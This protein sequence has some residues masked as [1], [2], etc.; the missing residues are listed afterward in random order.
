MLVPV[1]ATSFFEGIKITQE[2][3][4]DA[5]KSNAFRTGCA[6]NGGL[7][8]P[9]LQGSEAITVLSE[10][11]KSYGLEGKMSISIDVGAEAFA[12]RNKDQPVRYDVGWK[13]QKQVVSTAQ[14][15]ELYMKL[16]D[17]CP[18]VSLQD[19]FAHDDENGYKLL[20]QALDKA[21]IKCQ[22]IGDDNIASNPIVIRQIINEGNSVNAFL[23]NPTACGTVT[24]AIDVCKTAF[25]A[26]TKIIISAQKGDT[27]D[28]FVSH[29]AVGVS[30]ELVRF[31][32]LNRGEF[33]SKC[34][35]IS[36]IEECGEVVYGCQ[37]WMQ[38]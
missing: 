31:G 29:F 33:I 9:S 35:E 28:C 26:N 19:A 12:V 18:I 27:M 8:N 17:D 5:N 2:I 11:I 30:T 20:R 21:N 3:I 25:N 22:L 34:N 37:E 32:G 38:Q 36:R 10:I 15:V 14:L 24:G 13:H 16:L 4:A 1:G 23:L 6:P 7:N